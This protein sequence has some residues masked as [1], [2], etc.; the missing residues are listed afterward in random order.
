MEIGLDPVKLNTQ[1]EKQTEVN[2]N[3]CSGIKLLSL[4]K[5]QSLLR[6][7]VIRACRNLERILKPT[8]VEII[9]LDKVGIG[10]CR[11]CFT[12]RSF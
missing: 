6:K 11:I 3:R 1:L 8:K 7:I 4:I 2:C 12:R 5:S 9:Q 10:R